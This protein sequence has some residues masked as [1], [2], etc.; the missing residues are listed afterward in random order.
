MLSFFKKTK[1]P[2]GYIALFNLKNWW[3]SSFSETERKHITEV[4]Q[5]LGGGDGS[6]TTGDLLHADDDHELMFL[7]TLAGWFNNPKD[8]AIAYK[9]ISKAEEYVPSTK[10]IIDVHFFYPMKMRISYADRDNPDSLKVAIKAC[11][12]QIKIS[13]KTAVAFKKQYKNSDL[14]LHEGYQ[15]LCIIYDKQG[16]YEEVVQLAEQAKKQGWGGDWDKRIEHSR[17]KIS[18]IN[19]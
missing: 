12:E 4:Y 3:N 18:K 10:D 19:K 2:A 15:Q 13:D 11:E 6:L 16:K 9:I 17:R 5:P 8:R 14:P 7:S 1:E